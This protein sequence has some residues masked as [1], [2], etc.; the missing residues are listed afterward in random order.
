M[1]AVTLREFDPEV[2]EKIRIVDSGCIHPLLWEVLDI[3]EHGCIIGIVPGQG[4][5]PHKHLKPWSR[6][7]VPRN[8]EAER[9]DQVDAI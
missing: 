3:V 5:S 1:K 9:W 8:K 4:A 6:L 2:G 7:V